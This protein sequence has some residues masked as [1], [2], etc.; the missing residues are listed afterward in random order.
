MVGS[1][2][3]LGP[4]GAERLVGLG[5][6]A[7]AEQSNRPVLGMGVPMLKGEMRP[8]GLER[9]QHLAQPVHR[10]EL[11]LH[12][13]DHLLAEFEAGPAPGATTES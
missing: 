11:R 6:R 10:E 5:V 4:P 8:V 1:P 2:G 3:G 12:G 13:Q 9:L 7:D